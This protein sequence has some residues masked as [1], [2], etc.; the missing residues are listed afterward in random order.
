MLLCLGNE[1]AMVAGMLASRGKTPLF[2]SQQTTKYFPIWAT[3]GFRVLNIP[4][5]RVGT[6]RMGSLVFRCVGCVFLLSRRNCVKSD[7]KRGR[8]TRTHGMSCSYRNLPRS[9]DFLSSCFSFN[10][11]DCHLLSPRC[12]QILLPADQRL[13]LVRGELGFGA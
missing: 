1:L 7:A 2:V 9:I 4:M 13:W 3:A 6:V 10:S 8:M 12:V 5:F 11:Q